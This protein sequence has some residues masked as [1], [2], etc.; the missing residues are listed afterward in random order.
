MWQG[1]VGRIMVIVDEC[2]HDVLTHDEAMKRISE[3]LQAECI[4]A[5]P[6][7]SMKGFKVRHSDIRQQESNDWRRKGKRG[8]NGYHRYV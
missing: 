1:R 7:S 4:E 2:L 5:S 6:I 3:K 8:F